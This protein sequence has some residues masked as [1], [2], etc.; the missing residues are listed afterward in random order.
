MDMLQV[1]PDQV[2]YSIIFENVCIS[3]IHQICFLSITIKASS[4]DLIV[5][6]KQYE[7]I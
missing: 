3:I 4:Y 5:A 7:N 1:Y 6:T 2:K